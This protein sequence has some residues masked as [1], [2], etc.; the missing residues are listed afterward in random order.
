MSRTGGGMA[1]MKVAARGV[2]KETAGRLE[3]HGEEGESERVR[4]A[5]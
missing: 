2:L 1:G 4:Y 3:R 5:Q